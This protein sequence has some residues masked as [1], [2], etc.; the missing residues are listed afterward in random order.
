MSGHV[1]LIG[2]MGSGKSA[3]GRA[4]ASRTGV[5]H[6]DT[7][8]EVAARTGCSIAQ[9]WGDR[10]EKAFRD[11][12]TATVVRLAFR[13]PA[14]ISTGGGVVLRPENVTA[15]RS[16]GVVVWLTAPPATLAARVGDGR[17]RP[18]LEDTGGEQR[19]SE[20]LNERGLLYEQAADHV[21]ATEGIPVD[22]VAQR[23]EELWNA[24]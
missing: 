20:I 22:V 3:A 15:M 23:I 21:V 5:D 4:V 12:E 13:D 7:D 11:L 14:V 24:S 1:W 10:G 16:S 18:L 8:A 17:G 9:L 6:I 2:M 19:L